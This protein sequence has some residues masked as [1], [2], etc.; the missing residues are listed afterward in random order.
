[1]T[2]LSAAMYRV[3]SE[4]AQWSSLAIARASLGRAKWFR[5]AYLEHREYLGTHDGS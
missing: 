3:D 1:M 5:G 2:L 4:E